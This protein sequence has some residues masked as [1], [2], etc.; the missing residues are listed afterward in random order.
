MWVRPSEAV[1]KSAD[2]KDLAIREGKWKLLMDI[3]G[4]NPELYDIEMNPTETHDLARQHP[5]LAAQLKT[6][7]MSWF[8]STRPSTLSSTRF[9]QQ[10]QGK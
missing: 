6:K 8:Q 1:A 10:E 5:E 7:L 3:D 9:W 4:K 2:A